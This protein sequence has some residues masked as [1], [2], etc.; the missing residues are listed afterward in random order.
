MTA[1]KALLISE[2]DRQTA[3]YPQYRGHWDSWTG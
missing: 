1:V 2:A 3:A